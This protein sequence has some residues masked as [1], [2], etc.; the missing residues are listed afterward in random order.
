MDQ[1]AVIQS[2]DTIKELQ[3]IGYSAKVLITTFKELVKEANKVNNA[4]KSGKP[5]DYAD[6]IANLRDV[7][8]QFTAIESQLAEALRRTSRLEAQQARTATEQARARRE[9]AQALRN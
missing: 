6:A 1:L 4:F 5:K 8:Q 9:S 2:E 3:E 7:T